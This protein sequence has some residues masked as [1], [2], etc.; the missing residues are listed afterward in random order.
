MS[1][2]PAQTP[3]LGDRL[4]ALADGSLRDDVRDRA[5]AHT[6]T[7]RTCRDALD[8]E[9]LTLE[10]LRCLPDPAPSAQLMASL[11]A[12]GGPGGPVPPR[13]D[14]G[15]GMPRPTVVALV[16]PSA[17]PSG[18]VRPGGGTHPG[19]THPGGRGARRTRRTIVVA[20]AGALGA[21]FVAAGVLTS[22]AGAP[23]G[24]SPRTST[25]QL[26][27]RFDVAPAGAASSG[28]GLGR[29]PL[30][31]GG[32]AV[33]ERPTAAAATSVAATSTRVHT[34]LGARPAVLAMLAR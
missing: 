13:R 29:R 24:P 12:L 3:C 31:W 22:S 16:P 20:A 8:V 9:R 17:T 26:T 23:V 14:V 28:R 30:P 15:P 5:L 34:S 4:A 32:A 10:R 27:V 7:C 6:L 1:H 25:A 18:S 33:A 2:R 11:L 21:G 19:G